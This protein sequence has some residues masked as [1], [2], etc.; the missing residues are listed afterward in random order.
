MEDR[1]WKTLS[2]TTPNG[3][4]RALFS[5]ILAKYGA[6]TQFVLRGIVSAEAKSYFIQTILD[7]LVQPV[8]T[9]PWDDAVRQRALNC[10]R[11]L[12][13]E[14]LGCSALYTPQG[15]GLLIE[16][17]QIRP[18]SVFS[19]SECALEALRVLS[20]CLFQNLGCIPVFLSVG[21]GEGCVNALKLPALSLNARFL[22][23]RI[24]FLATHTGDP[25]ILE[26]AHRIGAVDTLAD[27]FNRTLDELLANLPVPEG[28]ADYTMTLSEILKI[29]FS[30]MHH[31]VNT[32][33]SDSLPVSQWPTE[34]RS[35]AEATKTKIAE[36]YR[37]FF[38]GILK[39]FRATPIST[40]Q[41]LAPPHNHI[42]HAL[43]NYP[44]REE[45][46]SRE[47]FP[48]S[49]ETNKTDYEAVVKLMDLLERMVTVAIPPRGRDDY[50]FDDGALELQGNKL[51]DVLPP[52]ILVL[53]SVAKENHG[54]R[55]LMRRRLMPEDIDR[56][57][58][59]DRIETVTG[60]LIRFMT[61][62]SLPNVKVCTGEFVC[63]LFD[64]NPQKLVE[65]VGYGNAAGFLFAHGMMGGQQPPSTSSI[66][67][68]AEGD[69]EDETATI[70]PSTSQTRSEYEPS[71]QTSTA[72]SQ[73]P[74]LKPTPPINPITGS[75]E[76]E[77]LKEE[78]NKMT[79]EEKEREAERLFVLFD[80]LNK[81]GIIKAVPTDQFDQAP[82]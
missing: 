43:M 78:W 1:K 63:E 20:N 50:D 59:L 64:A 26:N 73:T 23:A 55:K 4:A 27:C 42:V 47:W 76:Q 9:R 14:P 70:T 79:D 39:L 72:P 41:P 58:P 62:I 6:A 7:V 82:K 75:Y 46:W 24:L 29:L 17:A 13:R 68:L 67:P 56:S 16:Q 34:G 57:K 8:E 31:E 48:V 51:D 15:I 45:P 74:T 69:A 37:G 36:R 2:A 12:G 44:V 28:S 52:V 80:R 22:V 66:T 5:E 21:G 18:D 3:A 77:D 19:D 11:V 49:A 65:Y 54:A 71:L 60:R 81:T 61:S 38:P 25:V 30:F 32:G 35:K 53:T 10:L 40:T 33:I